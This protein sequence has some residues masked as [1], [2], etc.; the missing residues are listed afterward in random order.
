MRTAST[1]GGPADRSLSMRDGIETRFDGALAE[2]GRHGSTSGGEAGC[3]GRGKAFVALGWAG[4]RP[5]PRPISPMGA[6]A[7]AGKAGFRDN[8]TTRLIKKPFF[9][10]LRGENI[11]ATGGCGHGRGECAE[12]ANLVLRWM[13]PPLSATAFFRRACREFA[14]SSLPRSSA[15]RAR[16]VIGRGLR[17]AARHHSYSECFYPRRFC[18]FAGRWGR[19][20]LGSAS[21]RKRNSARMGRRMPAG[22]GAGTLVCGGRASWGEGAAWVQMPG[23]EGLQGGGRGVDGFLTVGAV[24]GTAAQRLGAGQRT[25]GRAP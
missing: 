15:T 1:E 23:S 11:S 7:K 20:A 2:T 10:R 12:A 8:R 22:D 24:E 14:D 16:T 3:P 5:R 9:P 18:F 19:A 21:R 17:C 25:R 6:M 13:D 4:A